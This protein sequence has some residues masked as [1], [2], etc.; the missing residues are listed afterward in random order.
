MH[1]GSFLAN[2]LKLR[3]NRKSQAGTARHKN[4]MEIRALSVWTE[5]GLQEQG[6]RSEKIA[7]SGASD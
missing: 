4:E 1:H 6:A 2:F 7:L 3:F 5:I